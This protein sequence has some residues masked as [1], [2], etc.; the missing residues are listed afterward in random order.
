MN[1]IPNNTLIEKGMNN[2]KTVI[3]AIVF[4][5]VIAIVLFGFGSL[6]IGTDQAVNHAVS[7]E[8]KDMSS[9]ITFI[10]IIFTC[11][12]IVIS[13]LTYKETREAI[14]YNEKRKQQL[15][16]FKTL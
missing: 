16:K 4:L 7:G 8:V 11:F 14:E 6:L 15:A 2:F 12:F 1:L 5:T 9:Q 3:K 10:S 13:F